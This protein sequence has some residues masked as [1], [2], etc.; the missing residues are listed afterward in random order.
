MNFLALLVLFLPASF[1][2]PACETLKTQVKEGDILFLEIDRLPFKQVAATSNSWTSHVGLVFRDK[3][4][5][6]VYE[7]TIPTSKSTELCKYLK[8]S[9]NE[10]YALTRYDRGLTEDQVLRLKEK[11]ASMF[12]V[13]YH[14]GFDYD[15]SRQFCS[16]FVYEAYRHIGITVG[17]IITFQDLFN[18]LAPGT[19]RD[20]LVTFWNRW[21]K[22]GFRFSGIPWDRRTVTPASQLLD[23]KFRLIAG[24][25]R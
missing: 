16:K 14:T 15:S 25:R 6:V 24:S 23:A 20:G 19:L 1:A 17:Q 22:A 4:Q 11:G 12:G 9:K 7:S 10:R 3:N 21:F 5:W 2:S 8:K 13:I 18:G